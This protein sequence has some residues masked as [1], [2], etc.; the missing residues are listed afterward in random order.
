MIGNHDRINE[1]ML[2]HS[3]NFLAQY[4]MIIDTPVKQHKLGY[5][6]PYHHDSVELQNYLNT[7]PKG[8]QLI[9]HQGVT[10][11]KSGEYIQDKSAL[12]K[13]SFEDFRVIS[14]HYHTR[15]DIKCGKPRAGGVGLFSYI[16][17]P[18]TTN[19]GEATDPV[20]GFQVLMAD[21]TLEFIPTNLRRHIILDVEK[22]NEYYQITGKV[23]LEDVTLQDLVW[24]KRKGTKE[25]LAYVNK[26]V[27][28]KVLGLSS[29]KLDLI[30]TDLSTPDIQP[31]NKSNPELLDS[32]IDLTNTSNDCKLRLKQSWR[33][34]CK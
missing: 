16:G 24:V 25:E 30:S 23:P 33:E 20:K 15:Q 1:K 31:N 3:L 14:G 6:I 13:E 10:G 18:F 17:N 5:L 34:L 7:L 2:G 9:M 32:I 11:S 26:A 21:G 8:S 19:F 22:I 28:A 4:A 12:P 27:M 29:F